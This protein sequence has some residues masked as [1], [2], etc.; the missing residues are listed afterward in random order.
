MI[1]ANKSKLFNKIVVSS[2]SNKILKI[3]QKYIDYRIK[4]PK[5]ISGNTTPKIL[6]IQHAL[7]KSEK[8]FGNEFDIIFDL[9]VTAPLRKVI[10]IKKAYSVFLKKKSQ[11]LFSVCKSK[12]N[13]YFNMVEKKNDKIKLIKEPDEAIY[14][15]QKAP[16]VFDINA[17]IY[18]WKR[19]NLV[20]LTS[21]YSGKTSIYEMPIE[22]SIDIDSVFDWKL[23]EFLQKKND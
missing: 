6:A 12:K 11:M 5:N 9:D 19:K 15:R 17:S 13:P 7:R 14:A 20:N 1:T 3:S 2:D 8:Y 21:F 16:E 22:R 4:R 10:D 18:I 23:V